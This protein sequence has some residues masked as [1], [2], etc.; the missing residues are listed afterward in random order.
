MRNIKAKLAT[1]AAIGGA[2][3]GGATIANAATSSTSSSKSQTTTQPAPSKFPPH[4]TAK[5]EG[6]ENPVTGTT[7]AK[8]RAAA[9]KAVGGGT[10]GEVTTDYSQQGYEVTVTKPDGTKTE[11]HLDSSFT[12]SQ[13]GRGGHHAGCD[14]G[15]PSSSG[16]SG[17]PTTPY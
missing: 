9:V 12:V 5:H 1:S 2:A 17:A 11:V 6:A 16:S 14:P 7:A 4:G 15:N 10:A 3:I 8:A 13:G